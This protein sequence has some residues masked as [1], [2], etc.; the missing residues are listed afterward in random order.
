MDLQSGRFYWPTTCREATF[1]P[2]FEEDIDCDVLII[3]CGT[4]GAQCAYYL[5]NSGVNVVLVDKQ[6]AGQGSTSTN[7]ALIQYM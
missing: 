2:S 6:K 1:Y 7:T 3:G 4:S 5:V